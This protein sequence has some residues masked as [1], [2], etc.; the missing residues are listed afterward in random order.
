MIYTMTGPILLAVNPFKRL[1]DLYSPT[2][3]QSYHDAGAAADVDPMNA[4]VS[5]PPHVYLLADAAYRAMA[6]GLATSAG[7]GRAGGRGGR[8]GGGSEGIG[9]DQAILVSG[10]SGAGK[11]R[12]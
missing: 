6:R 12:A 11:V 7:A 8:G 10:E 1:P 5:L 2:V 4:K 3:L 9:A